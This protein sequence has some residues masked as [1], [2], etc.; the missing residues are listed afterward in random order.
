MSEKVKLSQIRAQFPMYADLNDDQ[1]LIGL[2]KKFY[3][4]MPLGKFTQRI[5][6]DTQ[7]ADP[8]KDMSGVGKFVAGYGAAVPQMV[9]GVGQL[10]GMVSQEEVDEAKRL[11]K[12]LME[13]GAGMAGNIAG[14]IA[15]TVPAI[16]VPG[17]A[18]L[19]GAAATGAALGATQPVATGESRLENTAMGAGFGAGGVALGR[20]AAAGWQGAKALVEPFTQGGRDKIA[21]RMIQRFADDPT[22]IAGATNTP[23]I[24]GARPTL[25]EQTGD[26]GLARLQDSLRSVDPQ[27]NNQIGGR[28]TENNAARV[29]ALRNLSGEDGARDFAV[30]N[31]AGTGK[32]LYKDAFEV[33]ADSIAM[34]PEQKRTIGTLMKSPAIQSA[35][36]EAQKIA[37]NKGTNVGKANASGSVEGLHNMKVA[38][39]DAISSAKAAGKSGEAESIKAAQKRLVSLIEDISP[40]YKSARVTYAQMSKPVNSFDVGAEVSRKA[41]SNGSDLTGT[42]TINRD[43]L[44]GTLRDEEGL[45]KRATGRNG[46]G[47]LGEVMEPQ[48]LNLLR[49]VASETDR[50][51]A[52]ATAGR[53][54]GSAT[55]QRMASQNILSQ[56]VG[57]TGLPKSWAENALA[58]TI[59]GKPFNLLYSGVAEPKIQQALAEAVLNPAKAKQIL[60][61][62]KLAPAER[63]K[64]LL[65]ID[66]AARSAPAAGAMSGQR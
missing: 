43:R 45:V 60:A 48:D 15:A 2:H 7:R 24:T 1:L 19:R 20:T 33:A 62:V 44:M 58:N 61:Q 25:A 13:S 52:V 46:L 14:N 36:K 26:A 18:T 53:G 66:Q 28:L 10:L 17:A 30:A 49:A 56:I 27:I 65:L 51:G 9:R 22:K 4:D 34:T 64:L 21:G 50:A 16:A 37:A 63:S 32:Q 35:M 12:P 39:D 23:T 47:G 57:P 3:S 41:L 59:I 6:Y 42:P 40:D 55:A 54:D 5:D 8:T 38:L 31:R 29:N 11:E